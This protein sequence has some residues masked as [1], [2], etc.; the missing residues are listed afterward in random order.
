MDLPVSTI[1]E[2]QGPSCGSIRG[3]GGTLVLLKLVQNG[4]QAGHIGELKV[5]GHLAAE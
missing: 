1:Y 3:R 2:L 4:Q 5:L